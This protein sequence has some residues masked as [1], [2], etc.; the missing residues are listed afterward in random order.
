MDGDPKNEATLWQVQFLYRFVKHQNADV[1]MHF[2]TYV[3]EKA[4]ESSIQVFDQK[5]ID[6]E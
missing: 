1:D 3:T 4:E 2:G 5:I 6:L